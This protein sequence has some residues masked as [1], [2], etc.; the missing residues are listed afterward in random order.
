M[1]LAHILAP[2]SVAWNLGARSKK[3]VLEAL[4]GLCAAPGGAVTAREVFQ[5]LLARER[6]GSTA[7]GCGI[8]IPHGRMERC[9]EPRAAF[10][11]T[12]EPVDFD[13]ADDRPVDLFFAL[14]VPTDCQDE[15][16][17]ILA[18][19]AEM[20]SDEAFVAR[21]RASSGAAEAYAVLTSW[22][23]PMERMT[24]RDEGRTT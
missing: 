18:Q 19:L 23:P 2:G 20:F 22:S 16:L 7:L 4:A 9:D 12:A 8:A 3:A 10:L 21:L 1:E 6:L 11:R 24:K 5:G 17:R 13:A 14:L 15:H